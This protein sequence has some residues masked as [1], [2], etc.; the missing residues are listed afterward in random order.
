MLWRECGNSWRQCLESF[1]RISGFLIAAYLWDWTIVLLLDVD[2]R[3]CI[4]Y[5]YFGPSGDFFFHGSH[6][7]GTPQW[8][9]GSMGTFPGLHCGVLTRGLDILL[10]SPTS[11][12]RQCFGLGTWNLQRQIPWR[13]H[14]TW[15]RDL[16]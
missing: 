6:L 5:L 11:V 7:V 9:A 1:D 16:V 13:F 10:L 3:L 2:S 12:Y 15:M 8:G 14:L 4:L